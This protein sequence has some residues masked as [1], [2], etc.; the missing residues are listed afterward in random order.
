MFLK[1]TLIV[2][3]YCRFVSNATPAPAPSELL[4]D[5]AL[6]SSLQTNSLQS[7]LGDVRLT[8]QSDGNVVVFIHGVLVWYS[9]TIRD[10]SEGPFVLIYQGDGNFV[11]YDRN[12]KAI[13]DTGTTGTPNKLAVQGDGNVV[14]YGESGPKWSTGTQNVNQLTASPTPAPII[15][16]V[17]RTTSSVVFGVG[18]PPLS[19]Q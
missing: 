13:W 12:H 6:R 14:I 11:V 10:I 1:A 5:E 19:T 17:N 8:V 16:C 18:D 3:A 9:G 4:I 7:T 15:Q 2:L